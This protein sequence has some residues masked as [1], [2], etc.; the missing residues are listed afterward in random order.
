MKVFR[1]G[2]VTIPKKVRDALGLFPGTEVD[3]VV[4]G[5][6]VDMVKVDRKPEKS[7][8]LFPAAEPRN[9]QSKR[10]SSHSD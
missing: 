10:K 6:E 9:P 8:L 2:R 1:N 3:F 7:S 5:D 4:R